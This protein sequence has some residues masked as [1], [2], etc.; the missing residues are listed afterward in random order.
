MWAAAAALPAEQA[1][2]A[3][4]RRQLEAAVAAAPAGGGM[5]MHGHCLHIARGAE[6]LLQQQQA[7]VAMAV[8]WV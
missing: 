2:L 4:Q 1:A 8:C 5:G 6:Q 3:A 7:A